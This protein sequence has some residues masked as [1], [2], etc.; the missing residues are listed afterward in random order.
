MSLKT[1]LL[2]LEDAF[3]RAAGDRERYAANLA[4]DAI[5]ILPGWGVAGRDPVLDAVAGAEPWRT[6]AIDAPDVVSLGADAA[7]L[8]YTAR[9]QRAGSPVYAA[10]VTSVYRRRDG[11]WQL[12]LHQQTPL[13]SVDGS[14]SG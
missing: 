4:P 6:F 14:G 1:E 13:D 5:H 7:A 10:A 8:V 12:V 3:W 11:E 9:A 2:E